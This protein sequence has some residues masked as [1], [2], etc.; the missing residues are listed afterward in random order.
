MGDVL[1]KGWASIQAWE[2]VENGHPLTRLRG[3][4]PRC[5]NRTLHLYPFLKGRPGYEVFLRCEC[6]LGNFCDEDD[7]K[8]RVARPFDPSMS[9]SCWVRDLARRGK[10]CPV[11]G[12]RLE[13]MD[14]PRPN[15][16]TGRCPSCGHFEHIYASTH[17]PLRP[18]RGASAKG[19]GIV[20]QFRPRDGAE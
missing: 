8:V 4:C 16:A 10:K 5:G 15:E 13:V 9:T 20:L 12:R 6:G 17:V 2:H 18:S 3:V 11:C 19:K 1:L 7:R 14:A